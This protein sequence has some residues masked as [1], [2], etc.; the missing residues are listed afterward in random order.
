M[1]C[2]S[3]YI[4]NSPD[5]GTQWPHPQ[6]QSQEDGLSLSIFIS[7][8]PALGTQWPHPQPQSQEEPQ[9]RVF[10]LQVWYALVG[11]L[12]QRKQTAY[13][14]SVIKDIFSSQDEGTLI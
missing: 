7:D 13:A 2:T 12:L 9:Q 11:Q 5:L 6:P 4:S 1:V 3:L 10:R 8:S 14:L